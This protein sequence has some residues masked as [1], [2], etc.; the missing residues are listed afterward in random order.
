MN[1]D[2]NIAPVGQSVANR[3]CGPVL[4]RFMEDMREFA[5]ETHR[6]VQLLLDVLAHIE[7]L[8]EPLGK[9]LYWI[10]KKLSPSP[11]AGEAGSK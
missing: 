1:N 3:P 5:I 7:S 2:N 4:T 6:E 10:D 11:K 9:R 8:I